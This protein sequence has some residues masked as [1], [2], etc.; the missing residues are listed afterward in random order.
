VL[1]NDG[2]LVDRNGEDERIE[3]YSSGEKAACC[4]SFAVAQ[5]F[6]VVMN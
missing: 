5:I 4:L 3:I 2:I 1:T 6:V